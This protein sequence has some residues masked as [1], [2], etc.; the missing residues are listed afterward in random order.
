MKYTSKT[1]R[2]NKLFLLAIVFLFCIFF[3]RTI[4]I[5]TN[6]EVEGVNLKK[7]AE[8]RVTATKTLKASRGTIYDIN[9]NALAKNTNSYTVFAYL[10]PKRT[11]NE[12]YPKHVVD[13]ETTAQKLAEILL[14]LNDKMTYERILGLLILLLLI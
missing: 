10:D 1:I 12:K 3:A 11:T 9:G 4:Y 7:M 8:N 13:K 6:E 14:P 2:F 5:S